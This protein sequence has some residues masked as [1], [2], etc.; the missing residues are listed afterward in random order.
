MSHRIVELFGLTSK[1]W[2]HDPILC[3]SI[4]YEKYGNDGS[5]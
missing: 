1:I 3:I 4:D 5:I 2:W